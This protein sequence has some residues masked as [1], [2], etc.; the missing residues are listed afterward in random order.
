MVDL[1]VIG[2]GLAGLT[3]AIHAA[4]AGLTVRLISKGLSALHWGAGTIDL[5]GYLPDNTPVEQPLAAL[6]SLDADHPLR[7]IDRA[8]LQN[9]LITVQRWL[10]QAGL[11]YTRAEGGGNLWLPSAVGAK[12]PTYLAPAAQTTG[13]LDNAAPLLVVGFE[14]LRDYYATLLADNLVRQGYHARAHT[15]PF[16]LLTARHDANTVHLA[17]GLEE[18]A[19]LDALAAA[20]RPVIEPGER[21]L[22]PAILGLQQHTET[23]AYL[24]DALA[25][26]VAEVPTLPP[27][28]AGLRL[29]HALA[30]TL[31]GAGG[32]I[33]TNM[34][35]ISFGTQVDT[36][37]GAKAIA[38]V[39]TATPA[40]PL[41]HHA[42]SYLLATGGLLGGGF[43]SDHKGRV[44]ETLFDLPIA[45]PAGRGA[46]FRPE[47]LD[48]AGHPI[49]TAGVQTNG[50]WQPV[51]VQGK[52]LYTNLWAA[53]NL[54][55]GADAIRTRSHEGLALATGM[56]AAEH[57]VESIR[58]TST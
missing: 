36:T 14:R 53:G 1:L 7:R 16:A 52:P 42:R 26:P 10:T 35:A 2:A 55:A 11:P 13:R 21:V 50:A 28:V 29:Y 22:F 49:Y 8:R 18:R 41:R 44:W 9:A 58:V 56:A 57:I 5:L 20:L 23:V 40:R 37:T 25:A 54:L 12:R 34:T 30:A 51:D 32:R 4:K 3:A 17:E 19:R 15:L 24:A 6:D 47:F 45:T 27:S 43:N 38:W 48:Q 33:E 39:A 46:W 31:T